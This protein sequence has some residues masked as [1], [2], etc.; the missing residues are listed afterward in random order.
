[1][2]RIVKE[3]GSLTGA[4]RPSAPGLRAINA[5]VVAARSFAFICN[6]HLCDVFAEDATGRFMIT[7]PNYF[8]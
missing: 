8:C 6:A 5:V 1:M 3:C 4:V 2:K 7:S